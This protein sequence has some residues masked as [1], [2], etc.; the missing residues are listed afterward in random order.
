MKST[1]TAFKF[2]H[3]EQSVEL[4]PRRDT[5]QLLILLKMQLSRR[6]RQHA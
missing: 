6:S 4:R 3:F 1:P 2:V 5:E